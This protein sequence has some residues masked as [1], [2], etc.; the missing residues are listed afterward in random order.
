MWLISNSSLS[1]PES[2]GLGNVSAS[3]YLRL[4]ATSAIVWFHAGA[5]APLRGAIGGSGLVVFAYLSFLHA[6]RR[7]GHRAAVMRLTQRLLIP[8]A[9]WW[10]IYAAVDFRLARGVPRELTAPTSVAE[11]LAWPAIHLWYL[12][13]VF[14]SSLG[15]LGMSR[16]I[17]PMHGRTKVALALVAGLGLLLAMIALPEALP[18]PLGQFVPALPTIGLGL[19]Y[20]YC[21]R[22]G[23]RRRR[24]GYFAAIAALV[25][26]ACIPIWLWGSNTDSHTIAIA[27]TGGSLL[28]IL[29]TLSLP[30]HRLSIHLSA[31]SMGIYLAHPLAWLTLRKFIVGFTD[32]P[33]WIIALATLLL[34][35]LMSWVI[36]QI[37]YLRA[38]V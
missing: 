7:Y 36:R 29:C 24:L 26:V 9:A 32:L 6:G 30:R 4:Y 18:F 21:L 13:F 20:G 22:I 14:V 37:R 12:P 1:L 8:W 16:I 5:T 25:T 23:D 27:Y 10:L 15:L 19:V 11:M 33:Y 35:A 34:A 31:L 3:A 17:A 38:I 2:R 28:M